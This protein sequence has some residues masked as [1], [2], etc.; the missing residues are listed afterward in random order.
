MSEE[1]GAKPI[2]I[3]LRSLAIFFAIATPLTTWIWHVEKRITSVEAA[4]DLV[5]RVKT[6][7]DALLPVL[8]RYNMDEELRK[9]GY[10]EGIP[11]EGASN[12]DASCHREEMAEKIMDE[13]ADPG[14]ERR[15]EVPEYRDRDGARRPSRKEI[16][17]KL[18]K[19]AEEWA[20]EQI[21]QSPQAEH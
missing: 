14:L 15:K 1:N 21:Q 4:Q 6:L 20:K 9:M 2:M 7:E 19:K 5:N 17:E 18:R 13:E 3:S 12:I 11:A 10:I 8:V 16:E